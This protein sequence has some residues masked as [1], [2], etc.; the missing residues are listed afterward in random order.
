MTTRFRSGVMES[1]GGRDVLVLQQRNPLTKEYRISGPTQLGRHGG[2]N[3]AVSDRPIPEEFDQLELA[4]EIMDSIAVSRNHAG[5]IPVNGGYGVIDLNSMNGTYVNGKN[6]NPS[7]N[8]PK[9]VPLNIG[10]IV[11]LAHDLELY[12]MPNRDP[13][14]NH[15]ALFVGYDCEHTPE[16]M[17]NLDSLAEQLDRRG[18]A[19]NIKCLYNQNATV[20]NVLEQLEEAAYLATTDSHFI[21]Y[22]SGRGAKGRGIRMDSGVVSPSD[23]YMR[24]ENIRGKKAVILDC[25]HADMFTK[26]MIPGNTLV[27]AAGGKGANAGSVAASQQMDDFTSVLVRYL[28]QAKGKIH[29]KE[30]GEHMRRNNLPFTIHCP[31]PTII[32]GNVNYTILSSYTQSFG[33]DDF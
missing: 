1:G 23:L 17:R 7:Q 22:Y 33:R 10:D 5:I 6:I 26:G 11:S 2:L 30:I 8:D 16:V 21:F 32:G 27:L 28:D 18:F 9:L 31:I 19:G 24:I 25:D 3:W 29:L 15:H 14:K 4:I 20:K 12:V 13:Q